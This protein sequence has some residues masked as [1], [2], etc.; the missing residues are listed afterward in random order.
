MG[1]ARQTLDLA[2]TEKTWQQTII[3]LAHTLGWLTYHTHDSRRSQPGFPDLVL[4]RDRIIFVE[5]KSERG[6]LTADQEKWG[7]ALYD[8][9][10][11][12]YDWRPSDWPQVK[13]IL[14]RR[15]QP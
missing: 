10:A 8:A 14:T 1:D 15:G 9:G 11:E 5:L 7:W 3:D 2:M 13:R 6:K 12:I 4:V